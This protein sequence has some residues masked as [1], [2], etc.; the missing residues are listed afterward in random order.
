MEK[1]YQ[2]IVAG[3]LVGLATKYIFGFFLG[4][5]EKLIRSFLKKQSPKVKNKYKLTLSRS[6]VDQ[7]ETEER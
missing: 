2:S 5:K 1:Y 7:S 3:Q 6:N 4:R